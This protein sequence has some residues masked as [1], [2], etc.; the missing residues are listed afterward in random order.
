MPISKPVYQLKLALDLPEDEAGYNSTAPP[1]PEDV[2]IRA[3]AA[4][5]ALEGG[6]MWPKNPLGESEI[7][8]WYEHYL[9]LVYGGWPW[10]VAVMIAW[11]ATPKPRWPSSQDEL[12]KQ[13]LGLTSDRQFSVWMAKNPAIAAQVQD[14]QFAL[15][16]D[17]L[18]EVLA[19]GIEVAKTRDYKGRGD[20]EMIYKMA[21]ILSDKVEAEIFDKSGMADL[22]KLTFEEKLRLAGLDNPQALMAL[23][24]KLAQNESAEVDDEPEPG[25]NQG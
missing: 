24:A 7:P 19:A 5:R 11:L 18:G 20:R 2:R 10:R 6:V 23:K 22:S 9:K 16:W 15:V 12:A 25:S 21:G 4:R 8:G 3:E 17:S 1:S 14:V 13:V